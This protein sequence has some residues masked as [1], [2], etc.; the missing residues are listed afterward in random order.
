MRILVST[1]SKTLSLVRKLVISLIGF[2]IIIIGA[3]LVPLPGPGLLIMFF[4]LFLISLEFDWAKKYVTQIRSKF[5]DIYKTAQ[6]RSEAIGRPKD[7]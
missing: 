6:K 4:G 7:D 5:G 2:P 3:I 1:M